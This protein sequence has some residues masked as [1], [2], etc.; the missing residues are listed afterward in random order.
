[1]E[2]DPN[3]STSHSGFAF[4]LLLPLGRIQEAVRQLQAAAKSDPL[5]RN[6]QWNLAYALLMAG[7]FDEAAI[8]CG[9]AANA[10]CLGRARLGQERIGEAV[11]IL[12]AAVDRGIPPGDPT[13]GYLGYAYARAGRRQEAEQIAQEQQPF[14]FH[15][16]LVFAGLGDANRAIEAMRRMTGLGPIRIG[17][18]LSLPEFALLRGD[19]RLTALRT[20]VGLPR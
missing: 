17:R 1:L 3:S 11:N 16:A 19:P 9:A 20:R 7:R 2:L 18:D 13:R 5:S 14:A 12:E 10:Q 8:A 15:Q 4:D 6:V